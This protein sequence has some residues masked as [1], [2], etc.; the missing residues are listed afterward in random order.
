MR[1][2]GPTTHHTMTTLE[3]LPGAVIQD[4]FMR[5]PLL[6]G[7][8]A[9]TLTMQSLATETRFR[10][11]WYALHRRTPASPHHP[12]AW[13]LI[14]AGP[15]G[16]EVALALLPTDPDVDA[17]AAWLNAALAADHARVVVALL[18]RRP[19]EQRA[20]AVTEALAAVL[21][22]GSLA[23]S[24]DL[25]HNAVGGLA[26]LPPLI[27]PRAFFRCSPA[28]IDLVL[29][30]QEAHMSPPAFDKHM[31]N[32]VTTML[33]G[34]FLK[35]LDLLAAILGLRPALWEYALHAWFRH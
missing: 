23:V 27:T 5:V 30:H 29:R 7:V 2:S 8:A 20:R 16:E 3:L 25:L 6:D 18:T 24:T 12:Y 28:I 4:I 21:R 34:Q 15:A 1:R 22:M 11:A 13:R 19:P 32:L 26:A 17:E 33:P 10:C 35:T 9:S 14:R 31:Q